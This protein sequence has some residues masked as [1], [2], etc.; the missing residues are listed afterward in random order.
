MARIRLALLLLV[1]LL[2]A[3]CDQGVA[4]TVPTAA[5]ATSAPQSAA[6][7][8]SQ[9]VSPATQ[10]AE[11]SPT[12]AANVP[13]TG[14]VMAQPSMAI[15]EVTP[16][17]TQALP[18]AETSPQSTSDVPVAQSSP[19]AT[20]ALLIAAEATPPGTFVVPAPPT[21]STLSNS[22]GLA[23][24]SDIAANLAAAPVPPGADVQAG[25]ASYFKAFYDA[26]TLKAGTDFDPVTVLGDA[27]DFTDEPY[28]DYT[29][30][31][32]QNDVQ[33]VS[34]GQLLAVTFSNISTN[35]EQWFPAKGGGG[36]AIVAVTRT[37]TDTRKGAASPTSQS[38]TL[39]F[40][41]EKRVSPGNSAQWVAVDFFNPS[42]NKWVSASVAPPPAD[43]AG[44]VQ[45]FFQ[46]FYLARTLVPGGRF[47]IKTTTDITAFAYQDYTLPLLTEQ[48]QEA[49]SG[50]LTSVTY[51]D[52]TAQL[53]DW[54]PL[55]TSHGGIGTVKVT[56][57]SHVVRPTGAEPPQTTTY[58]FRV[59][60]H[61]GEAG[62]ASA[63][64]AVDFLSPVTN[65][66]VSDSAGLSGP[67]PP[68]GHG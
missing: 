40:K 47:N 20:S 39:R 49:T 15:G 3:A 11:P 68:A 25:A 19:A 18:A 32:L 30:S 46:Q 4:P 52:V 23:P 35:V 66:W 13:P 43:V 14:Q 55:A 17:G 45:T 60:H 61:A 57:T 31:Q 12:V 41:L 51:S 54:Y 8:T 37:R 56:R 9:P 44:S 28:R 16:S 63:W 67:I 10:A 1:T 62:V 59:H 21:T 26:R 58:M 38:A 27:R 42:S 24:S 5:L 53:L 6:T 7:L 64:V 29:V 34:T 50:K 65:K 2:L 48:Q 33:A 36:S 22:P